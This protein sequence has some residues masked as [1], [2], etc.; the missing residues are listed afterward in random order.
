MTIA[1]QRCIFRYLRD[2]AHFLR[3]YPEAARGIDLLVKAIRKH[4]G[5]QCKSP[6]GT[7]KERELS[8]TSTSMSH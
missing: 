5:R 6:N 8:S 7:P 4:H 3:D 1:N 2:E